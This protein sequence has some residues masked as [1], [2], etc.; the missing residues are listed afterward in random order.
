MAELSNIFDLVAKDETQQ[1]RPRVTRTCTY[2]SRL[3]IDCSRDAV[4]DALV[5]D[6]HGGSKNS[7]MHLRR[8]LINLGP[9]AVSTLEELMVSDME[10]ARLGA[11][12]LWADLS[13]AGDLPS[14]SGIEEDELDAARRSLARKLDSVAERVLQRKSA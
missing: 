1:A 14:G 2:K 12:K 13:G 10:V 11:V 8:E 5:C 9:L 6:I 3:G 7:L 4:G